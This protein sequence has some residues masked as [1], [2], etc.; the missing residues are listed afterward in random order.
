ME[1]RE[2][3]KK[4]TK[5]DLLDNLGIYGVKMP[6]SA[7]KDRMIDGLMEFLE[8]KENKEVVEATER[9]AR[10]ILGAINFYGIIEGKDLNGFLEAVD[11]NMECEEM[12]DFINKYYLLKNEVK[13]NEEEDLYISTLVEDEKALLSEMAKA[14]ELKYNLLP[15]SEYIKYSEKDYLGKIPGFDKLEKI[16]GKERVVKLILASKN[17]KNPTDIIQ[18]FVKGL[19]MATKEDAEALIDE[20]MKMINNVPLWVLKGYTAKEI[21][22]SLKE[23]KV[24]RN[25]PCPCGSGKKYKKCCGK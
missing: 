2:V 5:K 11:E 17:D 8:A 3:L 18:D 15:T 4:L 24:G 22:S 25:E 10:I 6:Q 13:Y 23:K 19:T 16:V 20:G 9:K 1:L 12:K 7:L 21:V 14:K